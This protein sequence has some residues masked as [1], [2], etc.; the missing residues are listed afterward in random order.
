MVAARQQL[1]NS[2][3][4]RR[5]GATSFESSEPSSGT[6][7]RRSSGADQTELGEGGDAV[8]ETFF[9]GDPAVLQ[10]QHR[11]AGEVHPAAGGGGEVAGQE[12]TERRPGVS[13]A[14]FPATDDMVA[15]RD[16]VR[17]APEVE[18]GND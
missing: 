17:R 16:Q 8:V 3:G 11:R 13:A 7:R 5:P 10:A 14:A 1:R 6:G 12:V 2:R 9:L 4:S 15:F 18:S